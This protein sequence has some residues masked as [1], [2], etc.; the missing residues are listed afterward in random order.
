MASTTQRVLPSTIINLTV[1]DF[2]VCVKRIDKVV[3]FR[4]HL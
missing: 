2:L 3:Y 4:A 1:L